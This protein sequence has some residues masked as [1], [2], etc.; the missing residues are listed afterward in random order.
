MSTPEFE[1]DYMFVKYQ[2]FYGKKN[3]R[4]PKSMNCYGYDCYLRLLTVFEGSFH[5]CLSVCSY[6]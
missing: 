3:Q 2:V 6:V 4:Q 5:V 1:E